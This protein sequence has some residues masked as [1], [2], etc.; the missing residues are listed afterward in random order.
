VSQVLV[1]CLLSHVFAPARLQAVL[2][3]SLDQQSGTIHY[4]RLRYPSVNSQHIL[5]FYAELDYIFTYSLDVAERS[6]NRT[7]QIRHLF[8]YLLTYRP[9][10]R[11]SVML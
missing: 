2:S 4:H 1:N 10:V 7:L 9:S 5:L 3:L 8:T 6:R 11:L